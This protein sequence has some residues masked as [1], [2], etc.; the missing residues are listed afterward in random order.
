MCKMMNIRDFFFPRATYKSYH[1]AILLNTL[2][3]LLTKNNFI[4][5]LSVYVQ[6]IFFLKKRLEGSLRWYI[7]G[8]HLLSKTVF[9]LLLLL[10]KLFFRRT[11]RYL[12]KKILS[13]DHSFLHVCSHTL[14]E[15]QQ[16]VVLRHDLYFRKP[17][18]KNHIFVMNT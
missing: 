16:L 4:S 9:L 12:G 17:L 10:S 8:M 6:H 3:V 14:D 11:V 18:N 15:D 7:R 13:S 5:L 2:V 1:N